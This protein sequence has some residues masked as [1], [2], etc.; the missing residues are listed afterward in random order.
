MIEPESMLQ[1]IV[2]SKEDCNCIADIKS[3]WLY[4]HQLFSL[5]ILELLL[6]PLS[7][8]LDYL[9]SSNSR[10]VE[11]NLLILSL[12]CAGQQTSQE[13]STEENIDK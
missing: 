5:S 11:T 12:E 7:S 13:V 8:Q 10:P 2:R 9:V 6:N 4:G 1:S 3:W